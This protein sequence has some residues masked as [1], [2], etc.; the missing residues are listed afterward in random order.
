MNY[1]V[2][3]K[4]KDDLVLSCDMLRLKFKIFENSFSEI[5][6]FLNDLE[7]NQLISVKHYESRKAYA[8]RNLF[9]IRICENNSV[10]ALGLGFN[11]MKKNEMLNCF[12]E[13]NP[14][15]CLYN[16]SVL[17]QFLG[18]F[19]VFSSGY[20]LLRF[21]L[22]IDIPVA[23]SL[24]CLHKDLRNYSKNYYLNLSSNN[25]ENLTEYLG[26]RNS[27]GFVKLYNKTLEQKLNYDLTRLEITLD[28]YDYDNFI[29]QMPKV[30]YMPKANFNDN[31]DLFDLER[32]NDTDKVLL[33]LLLDNPNANIYLKMLGR[34]K[35]EKFSKLLFNSV[36][37]D[38]S[39]YDFFDII[40][41]IKQIYA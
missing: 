22:A 38:I 41:K 34:V 7:F 16:C 13:F 21:D 33:T 37:L 8:Y 23:R 20:E 27:N 17:N 35:Q 2:S 40:K 15:K 14:N 10:F 24:V 29:N 12:I 18:F 1:Y 25:L 28:N 6:N 32:F 11:S 9:E 39:I 31:Y 3:L 26:K 36:M 5:N 4:T 19:K 30:F